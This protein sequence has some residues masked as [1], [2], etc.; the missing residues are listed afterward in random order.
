MSEKFSPTEKALIEEFQINAKKDTLGINLDF[1]NNLDV[2][3]NVY[4]K[5]EE[6]QIW[7]GKKATFKISDFFS[8][9]VLFNKEH[10]DNITF[11]KYISKN[12]FSEDIISIKIFREKVR[13]NY[14][15]YGTDL[16]PEVGIR[17][18]SD[19]KKWLNDYFNFYLKTLLSDLKEDKDA[20]GEIIG[21]YY[22]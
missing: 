15:G 2:R 19:E 18:N 11:I 7:G 8:F 6:M 9:K 4:E 16:G 17:V 21:D 12:I 20:K 5:S 13:G 22:W 3:D 1:T 14:G 10:I